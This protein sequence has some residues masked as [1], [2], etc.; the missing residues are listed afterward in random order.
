MSVRPQQVQVIAMRSERVS[1]RTRASPFPQS[2]HDAELLS[3]CDFMP[4]SY[5][6]CVTIC[7]TQTEKRP[8]T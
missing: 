8:D 2:G 7:D 6:G 4:V 1:T 3:V 5:R